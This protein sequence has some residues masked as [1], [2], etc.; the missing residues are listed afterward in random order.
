MSQLH[1]EKVNIRNQGVGLCR[2]HVDPFGLRHGL[3]ACMVA[4]TKIIAGLGMSLGMQHL[5][6]P[7]AT[8]ACAG[9]LSFESPASGSHLPATYLRLESCVPAQGTTGQPC[10]QRLKLQQKR[11]SGETM[12]LPSCMSRQWMTQDM[13]ER[14]S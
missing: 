4:P 3:N 11:L 14:P 8:G 2:I 5:Q 1:L 9:L 7:G 12:T 10:M 6:A 13:T